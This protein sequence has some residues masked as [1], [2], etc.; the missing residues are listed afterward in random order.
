MGCSSRLCSLFLRFLSLTSHSGHLLRQYLGRLRAFQ[1]APRTRQ[2]DDFLQAL[3]FRGGQVPTFGCKAVVAAA[4]VVF[5]R[6]GALAQFANETVGEQALDHAVKRA[7]AELHLA[8]GPQLDLF[9][10]GVSVEVITGEGQEDVEHGRRQRRI[11][12]SIGKFWRHVPETP[13]SV[14]RHYIVRRHSARNV[15][16]L[17]CGCRLM[18]ALSGPSGLAGLVGAASRGRPKCGCRGRAS[19]RWPGSG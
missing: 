6:G 5:G 2:G 11:G 14:A 8:A 9:E 19:Y 7:G 16:Y 17:L 3:S 18:R 4:L 10:N 12:F 13:R 1:E 15:S